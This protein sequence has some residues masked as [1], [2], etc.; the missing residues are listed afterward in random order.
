LKRAI[1]FPISVRMS[2]DQIRRI[3]DGVR[4]AAKEVL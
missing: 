3:I 4:R 1:A 2:A